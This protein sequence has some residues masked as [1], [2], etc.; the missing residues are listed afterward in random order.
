MEFN[1]HA[2]SQASLGFAPRQAIAMFQVQDSCMGMIEFR[3]PGL[4]I[5]PRSAT[6]RTGF[7]DGI[8]KYGNLED[9]VVSGRIPAKQ[10]CDLR[11]PSHK[12]IR[13]ALAF[14]GN[15]AKEMVGSEL[16]ERVVFHC[17]RK[18]EARP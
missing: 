11:E 12:R 2:L 16:E 9:P 1:A 8:G 7:A 14:K 5:T 15:G 17:V 10:V 3:D 6:I 18:N 13:I 4:C